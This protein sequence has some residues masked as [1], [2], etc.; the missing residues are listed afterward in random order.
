MSIDFVEL[1][2]MDSFQ[3][4]YVDHFL[5]CDDLC[6]R[7]ITSRRRT[8]QRQ[9]HHDTTTCVAAKTQAPFE[10]AHAIVRPKTTKPTLRTSEFRQSEQCR[11]WCADRVPT[12]I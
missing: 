2:I 10:M 12:W 7:T 11:P 6:R 5:P 4:K 3:P 1:A 8:R 9:S